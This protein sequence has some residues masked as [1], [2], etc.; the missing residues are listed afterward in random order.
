MNKEE[1]LI[2][3]FSSLED[4]LEM[5][6]LDLDGRL[7]PVPS[8]VKAGCGQCFMSKNL[9]DAYWKMVLNRENISYEQIVKVVF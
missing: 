1:V 5:D 6:A 8:V 3:T 9:D 2:V 4:A 7:I